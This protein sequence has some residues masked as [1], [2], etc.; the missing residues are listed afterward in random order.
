MARTVSEIELKLTLDGPF[1]PAP[2]VG[3]AGI[4]ATESLEELN[5]DATYYDAP[6]LRLMRSG[7]TLRYRTGEGDKDGWTLKLPVTG[8]DGVVRNEMSFQGS[9]EG[10]PDEILDLVT[11]Y[12]RSATLTPVATVRTARKRAHLFG[13]SGE[14]LAEVSDDDVQVVDGRRPLASF[15]EIEI[16]ARALDRSGLEAVAGLLTD[17]GAF[18]SDS[19]PKVVRGLAPQ[20]SAPPDVVEP[21]NVS[22]WTP[23]EVA[24]RAA[25]ARGVQRLVANDA[26]TRLGNDESVHQMRVAARRLRSD[27]RTFAP[28]VDEA[29]ARPLSG[30]LKWL[31]GTLGR[32]RDQDVQA[33]LLKRSSTG[34]EADLQPLFRSISAAR[35]KRRVAMLEA[36]RSARYVELLEHLVAGARS[37]SVTPMASAP[38]AEVLPPLV[39][40][41]WNK[42]SAR[43]SRGGTKGT[44]DDLHRVRILAKRARYAA[45]AVAP[46][47][48]PTRGD[49]ARFATRCEAVQEV[50][51]GLQDSVVAREVITAA[52]LKRPDNGAFNFAAGRLLERHEQAAI[53]SREEFASVWGKLDRPKNRKWMKA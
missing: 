28:L 33:S 8:G 46:A 52:A 22:P 15:R 19:T 32:V 10:P 38:S 24:V 7:V 40:E 39:E 44:D 43:A 30:G 23:A 48:G 45:E 20:A 2:L 42:L 31:A 51:G 6:D 4:S 5:L 18:P 21:D 26:G 27:L 53:R 36:L 3:R 16:E 34:L 11:A 12:K 41:A 9:P 17:A 47:L 35:K 37:P 14:L 50:L 25:L 13:V 49:A 1:D 29:W